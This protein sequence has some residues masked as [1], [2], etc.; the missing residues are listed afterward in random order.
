MT[1]RDDLLR[2]YAAT[3]P[4]RGDA[5]LPDE[6]ADGR[7][8]LALLIKG[9]GADAAGFAVPRGAT[10]VRWWRGPAVAAAV[11]AVVL[12]IAVPLAMLTGGGRS[13]D[14]GVASD[15]TP[16]GWS[17]VLALTSARPVEP[18]I[19]CSGIAESDLPGPEEQDR[20]DSD[21]WGNQAASF[22]LRTGRVVHIDRS[23]ETWTFDV[24]TNTWR[25]MHPVFVGPGPGEPRSAYSDSGVLWDEVELV[26]DADSYRTVAIGVETI[27][28]YDANT[29][30]WTY[31]RIP[32]EHSGQGSAGAVYDPVSG[33]VVAQVPQQGVVAYDVD[34][35]TWT[36][37]GTL[38]CS[39]RMIY[40]PARERWSPAEPGPCY[41]FLIGY[42]ADV[43]RLIFVGYG[44]GQMVDPRTGA[45]TYLDEPPSGGPEPFGRFDYANGADTAYTF[46]DGIC[47]LNPTT[48]NWTCVDFPDDPTVDHYDGFSAQVGDPIN[49]RIVL[50]D[51]YYGGF[52][53]DRTERHGKDVWAIDPDSGALVELLAP[54]EP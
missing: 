25:Q 47:Q 27:A 14:D 28:V 7:P 21:L 4:L 24:C 15:L 44:G 13:V 36:D 46:G 37:V 41:P 33:L 3:N 48:R 18:G 10:G 49:N 40:D 32:L 11:I 38:L 45:S 53:A 30:T 12:L 26:Y 51:G 2:R 54:S 50:I 19:A 9:D 20:P 39:R 16:E 6:V 1:D 17:P 22:D 5:A 43:D 23:G 35:D 34:T 31:R 52:S 8:P 29:D 42:S